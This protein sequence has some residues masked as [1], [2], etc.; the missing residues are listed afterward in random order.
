VTGAGSL[1]LVEERQGVLT[2]AARLL[3][4][5]PAD[6]IG[7]LER[8]LDR[9]READRE[10]KA[11]R[12]ASLDGRAAELAAGAENGT[13]VA[14]VDGL[15]P[16][17]LRDLVQAV[18]RL[19]PSVAVVAGTPDGAKVALAGGKD[20]SKIDDLLAEARRTLAGS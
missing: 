5:A 20:V 8:L 2:E 7:A 17:E 16:D 18:R 4:V 3:R 10:L 19:G 14:R 15:T 12:G 11:L 6:V 1:A 13:V 9:Q